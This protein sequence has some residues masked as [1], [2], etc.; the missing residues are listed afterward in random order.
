MNDSRTRRYFIFHFPSHWIVPILV[1]TICDEMSDNIDWVGSTE[2]SWV[3]Y[4]PIIPPP[5]CK[6]IARML[7]S[8]I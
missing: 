2:Y 5:L 3:S 6:D 4:G 1:K 7:S 8:L